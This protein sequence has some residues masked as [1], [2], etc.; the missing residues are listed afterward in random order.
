MNKRKVAVHEWKFIKEKPYRKKVCIGIG[1]FHQFGIDFEEFDEG[2][3]NY[4]TAIVE[5]PDGTVKSL[6]VEMIIFLKEG[7]T[8]DGKEG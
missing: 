7:Y 8:H 5:M 3:G 4:T 1:L 6:A 2:P